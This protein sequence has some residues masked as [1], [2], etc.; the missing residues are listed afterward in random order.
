MNLLNSP[1]L[2]RKAR[3]FLDTWEKTDDL[4]RWG[5]GGTA[6]LN[7]LDSKVSGGAF[8]GYKGRKAVLI[9]FVSEEPLE[10]VKSIG[11]LLSSVLHRMETYEP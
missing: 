11:D 9:L 3:S 8:A 1:L 10:D 2:I 7:K 5:D 6:Y 4:V